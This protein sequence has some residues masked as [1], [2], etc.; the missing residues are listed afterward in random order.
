MADTLDLCSNIAHGSFTPDGLRKLAIP[1]QR[2]DGL[3]KQVSYRPQE[4]SKRLGAEKVEELV[5]RVNDGDSVRSL[6]QELGV[7][8]SALT[9]MLRAQGASIT[10]RKVSED[11]AANLASEYAA[12]AT[13]A[14]LEE[15][16]GL[17][18]GAVLRSLHRSGVTM[19]ASAPR[20]R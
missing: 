18:H 19:R 6:A 7:A 9:R 3:N 5:R 17:S 4:L 11:E 14:E 13:M 8:N 12:G 15:K 20:R 16:Y 1:R 10:K 2:P